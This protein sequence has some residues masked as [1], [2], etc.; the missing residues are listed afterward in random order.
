[1][2]IF[3]FG[4][5]EVGTLPLPVAFAFDLNLVGVVGQT[6][7]SALGK[8]RV[9]E[10]R[11]PLVDMSIAREDGRGAAVTLNDDFVDVVGL[12]GIEPPQSEVVDDEQV[13]GEESSERLVVRVVGARLFKLEKHLVGADE[14]HVVPGAA[15]CMADSG[16]E[17]GFADPH[18]PH[19]KN[20]LLGLKKT[21]REEVANAMAIEAHRGIPVEILEGLLVGEAG[22]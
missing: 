14:E 11:D 20:V 19:K 15:G 13:G 2:D 7:Q 12:C 22:A 5:Q 18:T 4:G 10:Q 3:E 6:V 16:S 1:M 8:N 9:I 21:E 17:E